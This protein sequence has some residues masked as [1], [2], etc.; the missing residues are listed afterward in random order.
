MGRAGSADR[1]GNI[2]ARVRVG[3]WT[4]PGP[5]PALVAANEGSAVPTFHVYA[6]WWLQAKIDGA[7]G[8]TGGIAAN[9]ISD[10]RTR[11]SVHLL[12]F[13]ARYRLDEIDGAL[14]LD[15][16]A[17]KLAQ[18]RE[19]RDAL[20]AGAD[21]RDRQGRRARPLSLASIRRQLAS[22]AAS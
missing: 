12:P 15:F 22:C 13:F 14:C 9:T 16:K 5:P 10:Y 2:L 7:I 11:L 6:S 1:A 19:L 21:I 4:P 8:E 20:D 18:A 3:V 17:Y